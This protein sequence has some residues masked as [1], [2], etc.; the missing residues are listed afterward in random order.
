MNI[1]EFEEQ[2]HKLH[3]VYSHKS[4]EMGVRLKAK[5]EKEVKELSAQIDDELFDEIGELFKTMEFEDK[6]HFLEIYVARHKLAKYIEPHELTAL[7][8]MEWPYLEY[9]ETR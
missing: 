6:V 4:N 8:I 1:K 9:L 7:R 5:Y 2:F 3:E